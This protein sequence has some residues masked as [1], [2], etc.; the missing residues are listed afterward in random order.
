MDTRQIFRLAIPALA[1]LAATAC[2]NRQ[3]TAGG[4]TPPSY[5]VMTVE[6]GSLELNNSYPATIRGRQDIE[7]RPNVSGFITKLNVDEGAQV[8]KGQVLF[9][10][11]PVQY[12]EAVKAAQAAVDVAQ[13]QVATAKITSDSKRELNSRN[14]ISDYELQMSLNSLASQQAALAQAEAQLANARKN[15]SYTRVTSPSDGVV[16]D[17]PFRVGSL[18]GPSMATPLTTVS[19]NSQMYV[20]FSMNEKELL[21]LE[22]KGKN[23]S[24]ALLENMPAVQL[25]LA[26]GSLYPQSGRIETLSGVI[27]PTTGTAS[28]RATFPNP[29]RILRSGASGVILIPVKTDSM[30]VIPQKATYEIQDKKFVYAVDGNSQVHSQAITVLPADDGINYVVSSGL[31]PGD[32]IVVEGVGS[33]VRDGMTITPVTSDREDARFRETVNSEESESESGR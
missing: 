26:D 32:R 29:Q 7:I 1:A 25:Q 8:R 4:G 5:A 15:L 31:N 11:D 2:G 14:I 27:D 24:G 18:V 12:D 33:S 23:G 10:I 19:D 17:I 3:Q 16:G 6:P 28:V 13:A 9:E 30:L 20:Y 22:R 21:G